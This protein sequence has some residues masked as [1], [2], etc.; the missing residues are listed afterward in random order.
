MT[1]NNNAG[2]MASFCME[3]NGHLESHWDQ[4]ISFFSAD[5]IWLQPPGWVH[6]MIS[7]AW[8]PLAAEVVVAPGTNGT[9]ST[10]KGKSGTCPGATCVESA[11]AAYSAGDS[12]SIAVRYVNPTLATVTVRVQL[13]PAE[14]GGGG[15]NSS[16]A[17]RSTSLVQISSPDLD[18]ANPAT[19]TLHIS[20]QNGTWLSATTFAAPPQ[21]FTV[22]IFAR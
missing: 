11:S 12:G 19:D 22:A 14:G 18:D 21:S 10:N 8:L 17:W 20:P 3:R 1:H 2:R 4:G 16:S 13:P 5:D 15:G 6:A 9:N 7:D